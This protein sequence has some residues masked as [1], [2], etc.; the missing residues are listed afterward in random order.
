[1]K[2][3]TPTHAYYI[4]FDHGLDAHDWYRAPALDTANE[5]WVFSVAMAL[6]A[7]VMYVGR[8]GTATGLHQRLSPLGDTVTWA[9][10]DLNAEVMPVLRK[11]RVP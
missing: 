9:W 8:V 11:S 6:P 5:R 4:C 3:T 2:P 10:W 7:G 1:M